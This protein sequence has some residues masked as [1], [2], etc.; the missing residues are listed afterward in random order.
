MNVYIRNNKHID[1]IMSPFPSPPT[2][3]NS[4]RSTIG[5]GY[6]KQKEAKEKA[7]RREA[8]RRF[9]RRSDTSM[10]KKRLCVGK[11]GKGGEKERKRGC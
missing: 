2:S 3:P 11:G 9:S 4:P 1:M 6:K 7:V 10:F 5:T 8:S